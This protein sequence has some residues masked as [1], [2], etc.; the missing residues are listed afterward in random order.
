MSKDLDLWAYGRGVTLD[1][2]RPGK[3]IDNAFVESFNGKYERDE[4]KGL[5]LV[6]RL[7]LPIEITTSAFATASIVV[8][9]R[10]SSGRLNRVKF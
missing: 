4:D 1:F 6:A 7:S 8:T 9:A 10:L 5:Q 3:Q 2:S